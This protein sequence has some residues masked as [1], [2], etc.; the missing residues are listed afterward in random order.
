PRGLIGMPRVVYAYESGLGWD[1]DNLS[2]TIGAFLLAAGLLLIFG[3]LLWS[4]LRGPVSGPDP[5]FG[6]TLEWATTSPPPHYNFAVIPKVSSAYPMWDPED[7]EADVRRLERGELTLEDGH[8]TPATS[9]LDA[10]LE[11]VVDMPS[12]SPWP[13]LLSVAL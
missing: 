2:E 13:F 8:L 10:D 9:S 4:R 11:E 1:A 12:E 6:G 3:P 7:R 5:F